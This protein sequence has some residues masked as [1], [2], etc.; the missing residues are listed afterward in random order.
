MT[1]PPHVHEHGPAPETGGNVLHSALR[2]DAMSNW[3]LRWSEV[4]IRALAQVKPGDKV[5]DV[6]CGPG[7]LALAAKAWVGPEGEAYG[8]DPSPEM[9]AVAQRN[10]TRRR[11]SALF[12]L[13]VAEALP[14]PDVMFDVVLSRLMLHHLPDHLKQRGLAEMRRVLKPGGVC[15]VVDFEPPGGPLRH[16]VAQHAAPMAR[17]NVQ[18]YLPLLE[19][20]GF[21][22]V[23][24]G[25]TGLWLLSF[26]R[27]RA[28]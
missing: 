17:V 13:G 16:L 11:L 24:A 27:G 26:A 22:E 19:A 6:G 1:Q 8:V 10:A 28:R 14:F 9:I 23:E 18:S 15:L 25:P 4:R 12:R 7:R 21:G 20:A 5:L 3:L 2:Y